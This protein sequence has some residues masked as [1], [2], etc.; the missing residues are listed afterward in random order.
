MCRP[1]SPANYHTRQVVLFSSEK[2]VKIVLR[3]LYSNVYSGLVCDYKWK[4]AL[5]TAG[6]I[7]ASLLTYVHLHVEPAVLQK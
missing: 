2:A 6:R 1:K 4:I 7:T 5:K 3:V